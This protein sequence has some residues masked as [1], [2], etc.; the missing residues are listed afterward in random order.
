MAGSQLAGLW[1]DGLDSELWPGHQVFEKITRVILTCGWGWKPLMWILCDK[2]VE[3]YINMGFQV[4]LV[5][6]NPP[7]SAEDI[8]DTEGF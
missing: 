5:V 2:K 8:R 7:A 1:I 6:K 4:V 3:I